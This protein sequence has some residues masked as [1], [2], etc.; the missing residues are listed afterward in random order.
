MRI[1]LFS[2][3]GKYS[4]LNEQL[5]LSKEGLSLP[6]EITVLFVPGFG[7]V[8]TDQEEMRRV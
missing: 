1:N 2:K 7:P 5:R 3:K 6:Q 4:Q 8:V